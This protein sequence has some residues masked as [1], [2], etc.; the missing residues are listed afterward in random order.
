MTSALQIARSGLDALDQRMKAISNNLANVGTT[1]FKRDR[2]A[3]VT[4]LYDD[5]RA[6][7]APAGGDNQYATGLGT[8]TGVR[9]AGIERIHSQGQLVNTEG[10]LDLAIE[11]SGFF[12]VAMLDGTQ[13]YTRDGSFKLNVEGELVT[14]A[15]LRLQPA[16]AIPEGAQSITIAPDGT[17]SVTI[18]GQAAPV[19]AGQIQL[20]RFVNPAGL[21]PRGENLYTETAASGAPQLAAPG[22][23]GSGSLRQGALEGSNVSTVQELVEMI[24]TQRAYEINAKVINA[25]DEMARYVTQNS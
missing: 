10:A 5:P 12:T 20:A 19:E 24:E 2:A 17:V 3:F 25:A 16:I 6:A 22:Q 9:V 1:G 8:G 15:G 14:N 23:E 11:G 7:G 13:A 4:M 21:T 18:A